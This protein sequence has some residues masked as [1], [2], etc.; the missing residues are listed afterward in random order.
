M[1]TIMQSLKRIRST[2]GYEEVPR[3]L[4]N[5][6]CI[7]CH[8]HAGQ[9]AST[10]W[11]CIY[12]LSIALLLIATAALT[13][14]QL[15]QRHPHSDILS[16]PQDD[17]ILTCGTTVA[18]AQ[19]RHCHFD[20]LA[21]AWLPDACSRHG[22]EEFIAAGTTFSNETS[23][24]TWKYY[25]ARKGSR[26]ID[27]EVGLEELAAMAE[28]SEDDKWLTT[29]REHS[30]HCAWMLLRLAHAYTHGLRGDHIV[31]EYSHASHCVNLLLTKSYYA[32][33]QDKISTLGNVI[34]GN[35]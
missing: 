27:R 21:K 12:Q 9:S 24:R 31:R 7:V 15:G 23:S 26:K 35:C 6:R 4:P 18:E 32:P 33:N 14:L 19:A 3:D 8:C 34:F 28:H 29:S 16:K 22:L 2:S 17:A 11:R 5:D 13:A 20:L 1:K 30:V 25:A 10:T